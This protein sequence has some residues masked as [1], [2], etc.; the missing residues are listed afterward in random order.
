MFPP[1]VQKV[2]FYALYI[3]VFTNVRTFK[4]S[5]RQTGLKLKSK[6]PLSELIQ[7]KKDANNQ[8]TRPRND[9]KTPGNS[10]T[11]T[12]SEE[13]IQHVYTLL[14]VLVNLMTNGGTEIE[15]QALL[16]SRSQANIIAE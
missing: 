11:L 7:V 9:S 12:T 4:L 15:C 2:M 5:I 8:T 3:I 14:A 16:D 10:V 13:S 6:K 1:N